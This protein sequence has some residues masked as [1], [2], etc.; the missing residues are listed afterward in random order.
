MVKAGGAQ[1][2]FW[3]RDERTPLRLRFYRITSMSQSKQV[4]GATTSRAKEMLLEFLRDHDAAC[5]VCG[6]NVRALTRPV[7]P[8]CRQ[9]LSLTVG[10]TRLRLGW[11][12]AAV[13][14]GFFSGIAAIF[15]LVPI[16]GRLAIGDGRLSPALTALDLFGWCSG[17]FA[18]IIAVKRV[19]FIA[20]PRARQRTWAILIWLI[21]IAALVG[22]IVIG[23]KY[24]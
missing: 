21:H 9:E 7:C 20:Q 13:A 12:F 6:Y 11:L 17:A 15:V 4:E 3:G 18:V 24:V 5:P 10:A 14:P 16:V 22:F 8:E 2:A 1:S 19:R 23:P